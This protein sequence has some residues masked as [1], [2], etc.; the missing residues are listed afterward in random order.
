LSWGEGFRAEKHSLKKKKADCMGTKQKK[1]KAKESLPRCGEINRYKK[2]GSEGYQVHYGSRTYRERCDW[3]LTFF[4]G[5][6]F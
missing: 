1:E 3:V 4:L 2:K 5:E 6:C